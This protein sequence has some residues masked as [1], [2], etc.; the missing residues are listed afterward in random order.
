MFKKFIL[1][2]LIFLI[3]IGT[4]MSQ[5][6]TV[7]GTVTSADDG[8]PLAGVSVLVQGTQNGTMTDANGTYSLP[9]IAKGSVLVFS[10][11]GMETQKATVNGSVLDIAL[12]PDRE[13]LDEVMV[14]AY[15]SVRKSA[16]TGSA[17]AVDNEELQTPAASFD[18]ALAGQVAGVQ[19]LSTSGQPGSGTSIR[20]RGSGSLSASNEP[21]YV[22]DGVPMTAYSSQEYS[23]LA[24]YGD[25]TSNPLASI[26]PNDIES[27][28]VLKDAAAAALYGSRA[29][30]GVVIVTTK[31]GKLGGAKVSFQAQYSWSSLPSAYKT[32]SSAEYYK[33][34]YDAF[35]EDGYS[36][37]DANARTQGALTHNPYNVSNP[38]DENGNVVDGAR[39]VVDTDWQDEVFDTALTQDYT[40][41]VSNANDKVNYYFSVGYTDQDGISPNT[42]YKRYSAK[43]NVSSSV[44]K[45]LNLGIN[46]NGAYSIQNSAMGGGAGASAMLNALTFPNAVPVYLVDSDGNY[47]LDSNGE[48]QYNYV[49]PV[50]R[51]FNPVSS[52]LLDDNKSK[53]YRF[54]ASAYAEVFFF[55]DLSFKTVFS[56]DILNTDEYRYWNKEHGNGPAYNGRI[57][58]YHRNIF[59]YTSSNTL[60]YHHTFGYHNLNVLAGME[61]WKETYE[62]LYAG[63]RNILGDSHEL[64][65]AGASFSPY[66]ETAHEVM[67]S[68]FGRAEYSYKDK[69]NLSASLR[70]DG[71]SVFGKDN[72]WGTF[73]SAGAN[74]I[75]S[76]EDFLQD[77]T[78]ID[79]LKLRL[80]YGTSGNKAGIER[81]ASLGLWTASSDYK[82]CDD[83]GIAHT[84]LKND[85][86]SWEKQ[87][88]FNVGVDFS[89]WNRLYGSIDYFNKVSDGLL[90]AYPIAYTNGFTSIMMNVA[91]TSNYGF[92]FTV[93]GH[94]L[95]GQFRW[96]ADFNATIARD[97]IKDLNG[98]DDVQMTDYQKIWSVGGSQYEFY[99]PTWAGVDPNTG[100]ALWYK[101]DEDGSRT[102][103]S[104]YS[105]AT[106]EK[107]GRSTPSVYGGFNNNFSFRNFSLSIQLSYGIGGKVYDGLYATQMNDG[108]SYDNLNEDALKAWTTAG[109]KTNVPK[110][111]VNNSTGSS[112]L[113]T[114]FLFDATYF[115]LKHITL[116]YNL[117]ARLNP[118]KDVI[119]G[120]KFWVS[121]DNL[122]TFFTDSG[123]KGYDDIDM[124]GIQGYSD[125][126]SIPNPR[127]FS[128]GINLTF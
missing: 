124:Y 72:K 46:M 49:N 6:M 77:A 28:T 73:W 51:D 8:S 42:S 23:Y 29:A 33:I 56:P 80:S 7:R 89:F 115:K 1:L 37:E 93:G 81:Y 50:A 63:G 16:F 57:D 45:W 25:N 85:D 119:S 24:W 76:R 41:N 90:Y 69:Y 55:E 31:S 75:I 62:S 78:W 14:V 109:Q 103:T 61:Y 68:Y 54:I 67:I 114:R 70:T 9:Q 91:K 53:F 100:D 64:S 71:S 60:N 84:Q 2:S 3:S 107:Q 48:K 21:L 113:S 5:D 105:E 47:V 27:I 74:W 106:Y 102:T 122:Y 19:V 117:P 44:K 110:Y 32:V 87:K 123:F 108:T 39:I 104:N 83:I 82:Y 30:N 112:S 92:E 22:I 4:A 18:K 65:A 125:Y 96:D 95:T 38:L 86:L 26:N 34:L 59:D 88:M 10:F 101:V 20:I 128:V 40:V 15:G 97:K 36:V 66:S 121:A 94:I 13:L 58:R 118:V 52:P 127:T 116:A 12:L 120:A 11:I 111:R 17:S 99:M 35:R 43:A 79:E 98:D 126:P